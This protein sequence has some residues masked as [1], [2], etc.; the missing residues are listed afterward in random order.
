MQSC[1]GDGGDARCTHPVRAPIPCSLCD[2]Y[3]QAL[4]DTFLRTCAECAPLLPGSSA[5]QAQLRRV[6]E[7]LMSALRRGTCTQPPA[8][9]RALREA[10][11]ELRS[12]RSHAGDEAASLAKACR[13]ARDQVDDEDE[14]D[15]L[16]S[17]AWSDEP[18]TILAALSHICARDAE[19]IHESDRFVVLAGLRYLRRHPSRRALGADTLKRLLYLQPLERDAA[20]L[21]RTFLFDPST[22][23]DT[24]RALAE[25]LQRDLFE[26]GDRAWAEA[27]ARR[28]LL[29][30]EERDEL[31][32]RAACP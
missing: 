6:F 28:P 2:H 20:C 9:V 16:S 32:A 7:A 27:A 29:T 23:P 30:Q 10:H 13:A 24:E 8:R 22:N 21:A 3:D 17:L 4:H 26:P 12:R 14:D 31:R 19:L 25:A 18:A 15:P 11:R 5:H 1:P